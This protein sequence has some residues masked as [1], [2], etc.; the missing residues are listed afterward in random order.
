[1]PL[2]VNAVPATG[3]VVCVGII[4]V[5]KYGPV[6]DI[7]WNPVTVIGVELSI[8]TTIPIVRL[9][10]LAVA[11]PVEEFVLIIGITVPDINDTKLETVATC[12]LP[13]V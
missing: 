11:I 12:P 5:T 1:M 4:N 7:V 6:P 10:V 13:P 9:E 2:T 8:V 3:A